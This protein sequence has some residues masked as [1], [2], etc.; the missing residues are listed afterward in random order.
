MRVTAAR[1]QR[2]RFPVSVQKSL[3]ELFFKTVSGENVT[4]TS[5]S[6]SSSSAPNT[7][8]SSSFTELFFSPSTAR[9]FTFL[10]RSSSSSTRLDC[11]SFAL[12]LAGC[13][14]SSAGSLMKLMSSMFVPSSA[15]NSNQ[16]TATLSQPHNTCNPFLSM[17]QTA[18]HMWRPVRVFSPHSQCN[19]VLPVR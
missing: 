13:L 1:S 14:P 6:S 7:S 12:F 11:G 3:N 17:K 5:L 9:F 18:L 10:C 19:H 8:S 16:K 2:Q 4:S 15:P